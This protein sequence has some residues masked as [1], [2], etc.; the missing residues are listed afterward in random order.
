ME[1]V[2]IKTLVILLMVKISLEQETISILR[3]KIIYHKKKL[4]IHYNYLNKKLFKEET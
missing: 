4:I 3:G 2:L 1:I